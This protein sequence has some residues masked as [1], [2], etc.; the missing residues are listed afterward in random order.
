VCAIDSSFANGHIGTVLYEVLHTATATVQPNMEIVHT[1]LHIRG[2]SMV[3]KLWN[4]GDPEKKAGKYL[5][6]LNTG[7]GITQFP[8]N[9]TTNT[10]GY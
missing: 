5:V 6:S 3:L 4:M 2:L 1:R 8:R 7:T 9:F 10:M